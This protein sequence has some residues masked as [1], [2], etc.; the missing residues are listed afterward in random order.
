MCKLN[1]KQWFMFILDRNHCADYLLRSSS[2][3]SDTDMR[4]RR[5]V[6]I[7]FSPTSKLHH[8][9]SHALLPPPFFVR[10]P[11]SNQGL[12]TMRIHQ[13]ISPPSLHLSRKLMESH[14]TTPHHTRKIP[15]S[16]VYKRSLFLMHLAFRRS[17]QVW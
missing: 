11:D 16:K 5:A 9:S 8:I 13:N 6:P 15:K 4:K 10:K 17:Y 3:N 7:L 12:K 2:I 14:H 1:E